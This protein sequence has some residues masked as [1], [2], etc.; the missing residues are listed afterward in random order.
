MAEEAGLAVSLFH[1]ANELIGKEEDGLQGELA[2]A[3]IE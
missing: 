1:T 2:V 3:K